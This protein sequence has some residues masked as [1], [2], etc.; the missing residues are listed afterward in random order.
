[1]D[2]ILYWKKIRFLLNS[3][4]PQ[5]FV[6]HTTNSLLSRAVRNKLNYSSLLT[7]PLTTPFLLLV[8]GV[9]SPNDA[10][11]AKS[12]IA[13]YNVPSYSGSGSTAELACIDLVNNTNAGENGNAVFESIII[14]PGG[15]SEECGDSFVTGV[16]C[17]IGNGA[18]AS[19]PDYCT[20][21]AYVRETGSAAEYTI[22]LFPATVVPDSSSILISVEPDNTAGLVAKVYDENEALV[23][24][25]DIELEVETIA[26]S[27]G[28]QHHSNDR[29]K[30]SLGGIPPIP[31]IITGNTESDGFE[32]AFAAP[33]VAG[34]HKIIASC[35]T[36]T[37]TQ[38]GPDR[39]W[40]GVK[41]L[42]PLLQSSDY[43]LIGSTSKHPDNHYL[44]VES[45]QIITAIAQMYNHDFPESVLYLNDAS[46]K[47]G[48][49]FDI[50]GNWVPG[51]NRHRRGTVID[52]RAN[53]NTGAIQVNRWP[54]FTSWANWF[55]A[56]AILER[57]YNIDGIEIVANRHFH[58]LLE[59]RQE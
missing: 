41:E 56:E 27:G 32:F 44:T 58:V 46:L 51:H 39:V 12:Y 36:E 52:V 43:V 9:V 20:D 37:C 34:D 38:E 33:A 4:L 2:G 16:A 14:A 6:Q 18:A 1:M 59:G 19:S 48:G 8:F 11:A 17:R 21:Y 22:K 45:G 25:V 28:H 24:N 7:R 10:L 23:Q 13:F 55:G 47:R 40:V 3:I 54:A 57:F 42:E 31:H 50:T 30:G 53:N 35:V 26:N 5:R 15:I 29:P 49:L